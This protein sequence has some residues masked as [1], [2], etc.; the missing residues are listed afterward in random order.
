[1][2]LKSRWD[3]KK[4]IKITNTKFRLRTHKEDPDENQKL[5]KM[6]PNTNVKRFRSYGSKKCRV[7]KRQVPQGFSSLPR[8]AALSC[9]YRLAPDVANPQPG[10]LDA[11]APTL[12][13][14]QVVE[15]V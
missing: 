9:G 7:P 15:P 13:C 2:Q 3:Y 8:A 14:V 12:W 6:Y 11:C 10:H 1:M 5:N 4:I